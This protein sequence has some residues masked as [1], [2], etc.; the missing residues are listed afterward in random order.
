MLFDVKRISLIAFLFF[1]LSFV[2]AQDNKDNSDT[3]FL[4][5]KKGLLGKLGQSISVNTG[6]TSDS[7]LFAA[8]KNIDP[9]V[10]HK[11]SI[12]RKI[13][14]RKVGFGQSVN[15]TGKVI[16]N[17]FNEF[18]EKLHVSTSEKIIRNNLFFKQGDSLHPY[19]LA[20]NERYLRDIPYLQDARIGINEVV[21]D[22]FNMDS[23]DVV[24]F[25]KDVFPLSGTVL[26]DNATSMF[27][28]GTDDNFR[29]NGD[30]LLIQNLLDLQRNP[31]TGFALEYTKRNIAGSFVDFTAGY[32]NLYPAFNSG[33]REENNIYTRLALPLVTP[34]HLWTGSIESSLH[35]TRNDYLK[36]S[37][38]RSDYNYRY[39]T[40]D[41]WVGY[42]I[43]SRSFLNE[44]IIRK[45]KHFIALR[46]VTTNFLQK[47][48]KY[49]NTYNYL[50][51]NQTSLLTA[52]TL[53]KQDYYH[54]SFI[55]GFGRNEDLPE[56]YNASLITGWTD[57]NQYI[58]P[59]LGIDL[60]KNYFSKH[61][62]YFN[63]NFRAG[64]YLNGGRLQDI[65][66]LA[67][68]ESFTKLRRIKN[69]RWLVRHFVSGS[70]TQQINTFLNQ[71][72]VLNSAFGIPEFANPDTSS[73]SRLTI[74]T[75][76]VFFNTWKFFGFNF[77]PF[78][79]AGFCYL[80]PIG[81]PINNGNGYVSFGTGMRT[82]NEN[83]VF[84]TIEL[85]I[86]YFPK[87]TIGMSPFNITLNSNLQFKYNSQFIKRPDFVIVN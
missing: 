87:T 59:Y 75:Q 27:L 50:Y 49:S 38:F 67:S 22:N 85:K 79:F 51:A 36:D 10:I 9:F 58:R 13:I 66:L 1:Q 16:K 3:F 35:F 29:G 4:A 65:S 86:F 77:A 6:S 12:I 21:S 57:K 72:L 46:T 60:Q 78:S 19:L 63:F 17:I 80:K 68:L 5:K 71:P 53:F 42:N 40:T 52:Y 34:F 73:S 84:G 8:V 62:D 41:A 37:L 76:S 7:S 61:K 83:L 43:S 81:Q 54:T 2:M 45:T 39:T 48:G 69:S 25:Y 82:R 70:F 14:I 44:G 11:G 26:I 28:E 31:N 18:A 47:P 32:Q 15:D 64:S 20:D 33:R 30:R 56:G 74:N 23:V 55:Y 24:I